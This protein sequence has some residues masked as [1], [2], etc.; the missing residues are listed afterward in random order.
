MSVI[1]HLDLDS[2]FVS[3]ERI[4]DPSLNGKPVIVGADPLQGRGV[5]AACSYEARR[6]GLHSA[7]PIGEA[8]RLCPDGIY[9]SGHHKEYEYFSGAVKRLLANYTPKLE[10]ASVDEFYMDFAGLQ[11]RY[12]SMFQLAG[13]LQNEVL[14][15]LSLPCSIG[16]GAN[17]TVA[18]IASDY[19]KPMGITYVLPGMEK[20]FLAPLPVRVIPGVGKV[21]ERKL[22]E[23]GF[24]SVGEIA[25]APYRYFTAAFGKYGMNIWEKAN[26]R[27]SRIVS[28]RRGQKSISAEHTFQQ[29]E[30]NKKKIE[31]MLFELSAGAGQSLRNKG[32]F[33]GNVSIKL[34]YSDFVTFTRSKQILPTN[35]DRLIY[36]TALSLLTKAFTRRVSV[37][38]IGIR[39]SDFS[40]AFDQGEIFENEISRRRRLFDAITKIRSRYGY[41]SIGFGERRHKR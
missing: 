5:V 35:D 30:I 2:F 22:N 39:L 10:Q 26:G 25:K 11:R 20:E 38:L 14:R 1:F 34:R 13:K 24:Y 37:R 19:A 15:K 28:P 36:D 16:I 7:M 41:S 18:K 31:F 40:K 4:L 6:Y 3:V 29:N 12:G 21:M 8:Y 27:G 9:L 23:K 32:L 17:K 33:T